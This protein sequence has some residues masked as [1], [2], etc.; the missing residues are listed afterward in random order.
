MN[1]QPL[2]DWLVG[3]TIESIR[4][5][6]DIA[7]SFT[8]VIGTEETLEGVI[9]VTET[10]IIQILN[11]SSFWREVL[12]HE[13]LKNEPVIDVNRVGEFVKVFTESGSSSF[14]VRNTEL[15]DECVLS[16]F[17]VEKN[18]V[19]SWENIDISWQSTDSWTLPEESEEIE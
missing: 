5:R 16:C 3:K 9:P 15:N 11:P 6:N 19:S 18:S 13:Q 7:I 4:I 14:L 12:L 17:S 10:M 2:K 8:C 1:I